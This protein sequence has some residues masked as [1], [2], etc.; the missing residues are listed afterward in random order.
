[1]RSI[2]DRYIVALV[3]PEFSEV[4]FDNIHSL[5]HNNLHDY[6]KTKF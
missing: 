6:K 5:Q 4:Q 1:M 2:N 3:S